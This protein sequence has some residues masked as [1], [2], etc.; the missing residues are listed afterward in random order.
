M[1]QNRVNDGYPKP[2]CSYSFC[3][4]TVIISVYI[5]LSIYTYILP[6]QYLQHPLLGPIQK[7]SDI[8]PLKCIES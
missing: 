5:H 4:H 2:E 8:Q 1:H 6:K 3:S 7:D